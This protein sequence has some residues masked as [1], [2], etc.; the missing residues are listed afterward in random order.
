MLVCATQE[1]RASPLEG[2]IAVGKEAV[3]AVT[4]NSIKEVR[5]PIK[6]HYTAR[7]VLSLMGLLDIA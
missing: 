2:V 6:A 1:L 3:V 5:Q 4:F 7:T